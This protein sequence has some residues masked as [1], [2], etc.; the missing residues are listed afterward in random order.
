MTNDSYF[1]EEGRRE[2]QREGENEEIVGGRKK[3]GRR[4]RKR[5]KQKERRQGEGG[6]GR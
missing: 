5:R 1:M 6:R 3:E 2:L 4:G